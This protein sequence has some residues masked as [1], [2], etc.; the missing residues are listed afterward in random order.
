MSALSKQSKTSKIKSSSFIKQSSRFSLRNV[1]IVVVAFGLI[2][3]VLLYRSFADSCTWDQVGATS[4]TSYH[5]NNM[6]VHFYRLD[7]KSYCTEQFKTHVDFYHAANQPGGGYKA[8]F[9]VNGGEAE[10]TFNAT[11]SSG[12]WEGTG[13]TL[14]SLAPPYKTCD[15]GV[16]NATLYTSPYT[17]MRAVTSPQGCY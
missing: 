7:P 2:G 9:G 6:Y 8:D 1:I 12:R 3:S 4:E 13:R 10:Y 16:A 5:G 15:Y 17:Y 14:Y 11:G